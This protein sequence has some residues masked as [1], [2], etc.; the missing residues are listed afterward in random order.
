[1][2]KT[3]TG[4]NSNKKSR[5]LLTCMFFLAAALALSGPR[6]QAQE[7]DAKSIL[8]AMSDYVSSQ[9][10]IEVAFDSDIEVI[11]PQMEKIQFTNSG[12]VLLSRPDKLR[13]HRVG[14]Y[15]DVALYFDGKTVSVYGKHINAYA[16]FDGP[17]TVDQVFEALRMGHG[18]A[19]PGADLLLS[20]SY[21]VLVAD[22]KEA[23]HIGRGVINGVECEHIAFRN[24]DTDWQLWVD[25][26]MKPIP[27]K[28]VITS[29]TLNSAP[30]YTL[31][32]KSW[33][34]GVESARD[35]FAFTPPAGAKK[36]SSDALIELD[37]L[38]PSEM[39]GENQ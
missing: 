4:T 35:A 29:K 14:G 8:K 37:E 34:T 11:T 7:N 12:E 3:N 21:D 25:V 32:V 10:T 27:R 38:P 33:K 17:G 39:K 36:L 1:M 28:L 19:L 9:K 18:V 30:Q 23:K 22:V 2:M 15:S 31:R 26:G 13:A 20:N 24:F 6:A 5:A 16:Q